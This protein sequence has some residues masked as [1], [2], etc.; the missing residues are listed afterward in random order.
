MNSRRA[1]RWISELKAAI[2]LRS[3]PAS[4]RTHVSVN[5]SE[6]ATYDQ[7]REVILRYE[8]ATQ[9]WTTQLVSGPSTSATDTSATMDIDQ[10]WNG[11]GKHPKGKGKGGDVWRQPYNPKGGK[12]HKGKGKHYNQ[13]YRRASS[14]SLKVPQKVVKMVKARPKVPAMTPCRA[15][16]RARTLFRTITA[17]F[18]VNLAIGAMNVG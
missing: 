12:D 15:K 14:A 3:L 8:R 6:S 18:V 10:V 1:K 4:L 2:L 13:D 17:R 7:L 9:K 16:A 11:K 5:C